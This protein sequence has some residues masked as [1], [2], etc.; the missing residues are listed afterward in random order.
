M[1]LPA[2]LKI[3]ST[4]AAGIVA[5]VAIAGLLLLRG[6]KRSA[7]AAT[8]VQQQSADIA[9]LQEEVQRLRRDLTLVRARNT[10]APP[11]G[12]TGAAT[13][14]NDKSKSA[15]PIEERRA[16]HKAALQVWYTNMDNQ[17]TGEGTDLSW[18]P[19]A[20]KSSQALIAKHNEHSQLVAAAC[21]RTMCRVTVSHADADAQ[22]TFAAEMAEE[23]A[24]ETEVAYKYDAEATPPT[25][26]MYVSRK[27]HSLPRPR[28]P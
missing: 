6:P 28:R 9:A 17:F 21:A 5:A 14:A 25:T 2:R 27:G 13:G 18:S 19:E 12:A 26:T 23:S 24:L 16:R 7:A 8:G 4:L 10:A 1:S 22:R 3:F 15:E 20:T 11:P